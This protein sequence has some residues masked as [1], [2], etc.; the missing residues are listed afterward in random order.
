MQLFVQHVL[1]VTFSVHFLCAARCAMAAEVAK[2]VAFFVSYKEE[3]SEMQKPSL[4]A[5]LKSSRS[6]QVKSQGVEV[7]PKFFGIGK[8]LH[9]LSSSERNWRIGNLFSAICSHWSLWLSVPAPEM[10]QAY[11]FFFH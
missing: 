11:G 7:S 8:R 9:W 5:L 6:K 2:I 10:F 3:L 1:R 4:E